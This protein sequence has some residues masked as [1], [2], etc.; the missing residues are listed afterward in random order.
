MF[1]GL[2]RNCSAT[3]GGRRKATGAG[4][5]NQ[6]HSSDGFSTGELL[7]W[8]QDRKGRRRDERPQRSIIVQEVFKF[9]TRNPPPPRNWLVVF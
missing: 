7:G 8:T 3:K 5:N 6:P 1:D 9:W 2:F 4:V